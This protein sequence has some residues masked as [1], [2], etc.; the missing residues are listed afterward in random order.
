[1]EIRGGARYGI[2]Q[3]TKIGFQHNI[4]FE[5]ICFV[6]GKQIAGVLIII[7]SLGGVGAPPPL[8]VLLAQ[9]TVCQER[10]TAASQVKFLRVLSKLLGR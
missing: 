1:M 6:E 8:R 3:Q 9:V 10:Q 2:W 5:M 4:Y 7:V